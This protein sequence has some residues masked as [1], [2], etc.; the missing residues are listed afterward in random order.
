MAGQ[1]TNLADR[2]ARRAGR[3]AKLTLDQVL[4]AAIEL[5]VEDVAIATLAEHL[6]TGIAAIYRVVESRSELTRLAA[7]R[8]AEKFEAPTDC[9]QEWAVYAVEHAQALFRLQISD[10]S[11][12]Q[13]YIVGGLGPEFGLPSAEKAVGAFCQRGFEPE[14]AFRLLQGLANIAGAAAI[15]V[16][17]LRNARKAG[18]PHNEQTLSVIASAKPG[19]FKYMKSLADAYANEA[20][21]SSWHDILLSYLTGIATQRGETLRPSELPGALEA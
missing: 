19:Q 17:H 14:A 9:G 10:D 21:F 1:K 12:I 20:E 8:L 13:R 11:M 15:R 2:P 6:G 18:R 7:G 5:G 4:D 3:P 16:M